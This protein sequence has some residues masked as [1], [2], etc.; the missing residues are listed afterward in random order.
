MSPIPDCDG[1]NK[2]RVGIS[3][4][5]ILSIDDDQEA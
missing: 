2:K 3:T 5:A 4:I 1:V